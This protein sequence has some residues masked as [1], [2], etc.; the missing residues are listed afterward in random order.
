MTLFGVTTECDRDC[1]MTIS[2]QTY[3]NTTI[4]LDTIDETWDETA[5]AGSSIYGTAMTGQQAT[6][7]DGISS[8]E[9]GQVWNI[10][11]ITIPAFS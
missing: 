6:S 8:S 3:S 2:P 7:V 5:F 9:G 11:S 10:E 4:N 1:V